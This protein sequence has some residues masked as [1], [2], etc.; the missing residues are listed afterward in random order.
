MMFIYHV[1]VGGCTL[2]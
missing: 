1:K 2:Y